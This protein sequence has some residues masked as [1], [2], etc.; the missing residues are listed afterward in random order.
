METIIVVQF[1]VAVCNVADMEDAYRHFLWVNTA[2]PLLDVL[3]QVL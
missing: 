1:I 3:K 2:I